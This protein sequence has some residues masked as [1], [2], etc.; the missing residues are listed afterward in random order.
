MKKSKR[1]SQ[2]IIEKA[3]LEVK[4]FRAMYEKLEQ[5]AQLGGL[6]NSTLTN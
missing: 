4:G 6:S 2:T 1:K 3:K 5:K